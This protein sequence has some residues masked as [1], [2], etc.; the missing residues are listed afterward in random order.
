MAETVF[1]KY[2]KKLHAAR[3][4]FSREKNGHSRFQYAYAVLLLLAFVLVGTL[5]APEY[6]TFKYAEYK[7]GTIAKED[8]IAPEI[9]PIVKTQE[10]VDQERQEARERIL[11]QFFRDRATEQNAVDNIAS[12]FDRL[13]DYCRLNRQ[14][15]EARQQTRITQAGNDTLLLQSID[16]MRSRLDAEV[17]YFKS[18][19]NIDV[20]RP[21]WD[22]VRDMGDAMF[23][24]FRYNCIQ[25]VKD[26]L[27]VGYHNAPTRSREFENITINIMDEGSESTHNINAFFDSESV[28]D[29]IPQ[30]LQSYY[31]SQSDT[32]YVGYDLIRN[33]IIPNIKYDG[34]LTKT[35]RDTAVR[36]VPL[37]RG[38]I[39]KGVR[40]ISANQE[41]TEDH[42][43][44][45]E[46]L[47]V[48]LTEQSI[49]QNPFTLPLM[50]LGQAGYLAIIMLVF[51][52]YLLQYRPRLMKDPRKISML[53]L[54]FTI[55][56]VFIYI[57]TQQLG[58]SEYLIP[59][60]IGSMLLAILFDG[61]VG[62]Y[63]TIVIAFMV[64][65]LL[66][67]EFVIT[68]LALVGGVVSVMAVRRIRTRGQLFKAT[69]YIFAA[70]ALVLFVTGFMQLMSVTDL[71]L[72]VF[73]YSLPNAIFSPLITLGFLALFESI[74]GGATDMTLLELSDLNRPL[75][76]DLAMR[77]PG[78]YHHSIIL[79]NLSE[80]AAEAIEANSLLARVG[81]YYHDIGKMVKPEYFIENQP[82]AKERHES[83]APSMSSI[84]ISSHVRDG[85]EIAKK[86][87]LPQ[88]I[89]DFI[90]QHHG[91]SKISFFYEK[92]VEKSGEKYV[93]ESDFRYPGPKPQTKETGI[94]MLADG[95]E[96]ATRALK[97][98]SPARI[99]ER[100]RSIV[101]QKFQEGQLDECE[102]TLR[103]LRA[104]SESFIQILT[105]IFHVRIEYPGQE[106]E[107][108]GRE[109]D[110]SDADNKSGTGQK[111][112][113]ETSESR[114]KDK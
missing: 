25:V 19:P 27:A 44:N 75:L 48:Y 91:T 108:D 53:F 33:V 95:V 114:K 58:L 16:E 20:T 31:S 88:I 6:K 83:L 78:T 69:I 4:G 9:I 77:A 66:E 28:Q 90:S 105:G 54:I 101:E 100:V 36:Q 24:R 22:F 50:Y 92:A 109:K 46:S 68:V 32:V 55:Q 15:N 21:S 111:Q 18:E 93:N 42:F 63:G 8:I 85:L 56:L 41:V 47:R 12:L 64:G 96:A 98:P 106:E 113:S 52:S 17:D 67:H 51:A 99:S 103:D 76:R 65:G 5:L 13:A 71:S 102:L 2:L 84:I 112:Q 80:R 30:R 35:L 87:K 110:K 79:G 107:E 38:Y 14:L 43:R 39:G 11:A 29:E 3:S 40:I 59:T 73:K 86:Y 74:F 26:I 1:R 7:P 62:F 57:I 60:T 34:D 72:T 70:Y 10:E 45:I 89:Q 81:C 82:D 97:D 23:E 37:F 104:I 49:L 94:V 61:G